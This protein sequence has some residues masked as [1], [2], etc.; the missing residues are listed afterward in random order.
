MSKHDV[1]RLKQSLLSL[2]EVHMA[3]ARELEKQCREETALAEVILKTVKGE[4][5]Q[6]SYTA[7][8]RERT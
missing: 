4:I 8:V 6:I 3:N 7:T 1:E 2:A 5:D